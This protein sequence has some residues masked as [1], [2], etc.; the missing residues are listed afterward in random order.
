MF[1]WMLADSHGRWFLPLIFLPI[2]LLLVFVGVILGL[3]L[4]GRFKRR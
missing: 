2:D 3:R 4:E 1:A